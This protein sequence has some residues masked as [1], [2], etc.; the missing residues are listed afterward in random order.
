MYFL[1]SNPRPETSG[2]IATEYVAHDPGDWDPAL[3]AEPHYNLYSLNWTH[4]VIHGHNLHHTR[5]SP[6]PCSGF[7]LS[8]GNILRAH[9]RLLKSPSRRDTY[10]LVIRMQGVRT[11]GRHCYNPAVT[12]PLL[13]TRSV[14]QSPH[15]C[16]GH[17]TFSR[18]SV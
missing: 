16:T 2:H 8:N 14:F 6:R 3:M 11:H 18:P 4:F 9:K 15:V 17:P 13:L 10:C 7:T 1:C 12:A 5:S